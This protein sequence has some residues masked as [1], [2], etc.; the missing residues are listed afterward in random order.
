MPKYIDRKVKRGI[1]YKRCGY[2][3]KYRPESEFNYR[4][5]AS[6]HLQVYCRSCNSEYCKNWHKEHRG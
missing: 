6:D 2:C 3:H 1:I 4:T 5:D